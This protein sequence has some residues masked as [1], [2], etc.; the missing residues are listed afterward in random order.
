MINGSG[1]GDEGGEVH[2]MIGPGKDLIA[3]AG[4]VWRN[5]QIFATVPDATTVPSFNGTIYIIRI[6]DKKLSN[7]MAF[8]FD[9]TLEMR[10]IHAT[11]DRV[12]AWPFIVSSPANLIERSSVNFFAG[13]KGNDVLFGNSRLKNGWIADDAFVQCEQQK[14]VI[15][16]FCDGGAYVWETRRGTDW[17]YLNVR[18][19]LDPAPFASYSHLYYTFSVRI[20]GPKGLPDGLVV[21]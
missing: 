19:W 11:I 15:L 10:E 6:T 17:P 3:P 5:D 2:F 20:I 8:R 18:W 7:L 4:V 16:N 9:P 14:Y 13:F 1:F 21:P 12:L